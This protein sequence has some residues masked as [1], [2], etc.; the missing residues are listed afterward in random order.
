MQ[1]NKLHQKKLNSS[2]DE[3]KID[4]L[5]NLTVP[6]KNVLSLEML[7]DF[8]KQSLGENDSLKSVLFKKI[9]KE[10]DDAP[11]L[12]GPIQD[13]SILD[14]HQEFIEM[15]MSAVFPIASR[16]IDIGA[17][18][19]PFTPQTVFSTP[20]FKKIWH[21]SAGSDNFVPTV[22]DKTLYFVV[23]L[24]A[25]RT[26][27]KNFYNVQIDWDYPLIA[28]A[29]DPDTKLESFYKISIDPRF[30][31]VKNL[32]K[33]KPLSAQNRKRILEKLTDLNLLMEI[34]TPQNFEFQGFIVYKAIDITNHEIISK[35]KHDLTHRDP[36]K[37]ENTY[38]GVLQKMRS[39][40]KLPEME[41]GLV[42]IKNE[43][44]LIFG[45]GFKIS[46][47]L[48]LKNTDDY[49]DKQISDS[50]YGKVLK[51][52][53]QIV[54]ADL[55]SYSGKT[56]IE[57]DI[58]KQGINNI[59]LAPILY[60]EEIIGIME[61]VS[62]NADDIN[63][64]SVLQLN[65]VL[66]LFAM[67][68]KRS[69]QE[70]YNRIQSIIKEKC[71]AIH[72]SVEWRFQNAA[73][74]MLLKG[75][76]HQSVEME[77]IIFDDVYSL[78]GLSDIRGSSTQR[79]KVIQEDL[80]ELLDNAKKII[81]TAIKF[82][83]LPILGE[84]NY[85]IEK[86][87]NKIARRLISDDEEQIIEFLRT[88]VE[89]HF[90]RLSEFDKAV[91]QKIKEYKSAIDPKLGFI[92]KGRK[93]FESSVTRINEVISSFIEVEEEKMQDVFPHY[94]EKYKTDGVDYNIYIGDS[95]VDDRKFDLF[96]LKNV[97]LWQLI[98]MCGVVKKTLELKREMEMPLDTAHLILVQ[99]TPISIQFRFDEKRFDVN[100]A[101]NV[102][103]EILKKRIDKAVI[104]GSNERLTQ[105]GKI[106]IVYSQVKDAIEYKKYLDYLQAEK[107]IS[108]KIED[109]E[110]EDLQGVQ[111]LKAIRVEVNADINTASE[112]IIPEKIEQTIKEMTQ[113]TI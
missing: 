26:I 17:A 22:D 71:T 6:F 79:N 109:L 107:Y 87:M 113:S 88:E 9:Q 68:M 32:G 112:A 54:I 46:H 84:L 3:Y 93:A 105:P 81:T 94:F 75:R 16:D 47:S 45:C 59:V 37:C 80:I 111:G 61:L 53:K 74:N 78:Y 58:L 67:A 30:V 34:I 35:L 8:W 50:I 110:I 48:I 99:S 108:D 4:Y 104:K 5:K 12:S 31:K 19:I 98:L 57:K 21:P 27:L 14:K 51:S 85:R 41:M 89:P 1:D 97:R 86:N 73:F 33:I 82:K 20:A 91:D 103:Y 95:L 2:N 70:F 15:L 39:L 102:K 42:G 44:K 29:I 83:D 25:Y 38:S 36:L 72:P 66:S 7:I 23:M 96:Y 77:P 100:G 13:I 69:M 90:E 18:I 52:K 62:P 65:E 43:E 55:N 28:S 63:A 49:S 11:E 76:E 40:L 92:Y 64:F 60:G 106:A 10:L 56:K 24:N 101:Y